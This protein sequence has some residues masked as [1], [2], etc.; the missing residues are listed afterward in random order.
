[1]EYQ[2]VIELIDTT[3]D[4]V[5]RF[6]TNKWIEVDDQSG[7]SY[8]INKEIRFK[9]SMLRSYICDYSDAYIAIKEAITVKLEKDRAIDG[10]NRNLI[11]KSNMPLI[12]SEINNVDMV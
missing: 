8:N 6:I 7:G 12:N 4:N 9:T 3:S 5:P 11:L 10:F 2:K 1:M